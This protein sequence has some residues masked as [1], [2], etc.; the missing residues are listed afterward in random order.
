MADFAA[1]IL[2][3][4]DSANS[5]EKPNEL[6]FE[7]VMKEAH[8]ATNQVTKYPV[9]TGFLVSDH[10]IKQNREVVLEVRAGNTMLGIDGAQDPNKLSPELAHD[11]FTTI[12][13]EG[14][15][16]DLETI[17]G[18]YVNCVLRSHT[19]VVDEKTATILSTTLL[20]EEL[21]VIPESGTTTAVQSTR[22][23]DADQVAQVT[24]TTGA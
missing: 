1:A 11:L 5:L 18:P 7:C 12:T 6:T 13:L 2:S 21:I 3:Y 16:C 15:L 24:T 14:R 20:F 4:A 19:P 22:T 9:Q 23:A 17:L 8:K 10:T